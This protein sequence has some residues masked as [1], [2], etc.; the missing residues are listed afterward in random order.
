MIDSRAYPMSPVNC[1]CKV[2]FSFVTSPAKNLQLNF[3]IADPALEYF[4]GS[5]AMPRC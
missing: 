1:T 5:S 3:K 2:G 4:G